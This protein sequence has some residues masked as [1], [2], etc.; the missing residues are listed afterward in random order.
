MLVTKPYQIG[1]YET[2]HGI[3]HKYDRFGSDQTQAVTHRMET[4]FA[5]KGYLYAAVIEIGIDDLLAHIGIFFGQNQNDLEVFKS[6]EE[7]FEG[8]V[9][10][11]LFVQHQE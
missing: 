1:A 6:F 8:M 5:A 9:E 3:M 7:G 10:N 2:A 4:G 11:G